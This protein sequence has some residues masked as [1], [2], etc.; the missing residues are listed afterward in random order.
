MVVNERASV[1]GRRDRTHYLYLAVIGAVRPS[2][3]D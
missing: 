3:D 2:S 1:T